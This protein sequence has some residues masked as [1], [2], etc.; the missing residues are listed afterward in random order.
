MRTLFICCLYWGLTK[1]HGVDG[2]P[3]YAYTSSASDQRSLYPGGQHT[4]A[5][6]TKYVAPSWLNDIQASMS[7]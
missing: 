2:T 7:A 1:E 4:L 3:G 5:F 6:Y